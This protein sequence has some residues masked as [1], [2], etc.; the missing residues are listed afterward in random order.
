MVI[1]VCFLMT[2][3]GPQA[4]AGDH[5]DEIQLKK[6]FFSPLKFYQGDGDKH[7]V[8]TF[9]GLSFA[10]E[11]DEVISQNPEARKEAEKS[12]VWNGF[13]LIG[14]IGLFT[15][16][17]MI[18]LDTIDDAQK[19]SDGQMVDDD[20]NWNY[21]VYIGIAG[22]VMILSS[23]MSSSYLKRGIKI[24][25]DG[26]VTDDATGSSIL[27]NFRIYVDVDTENRVPGTEEPTKRLL[28]ANSS[29]KFGVSF[30]F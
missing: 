15:V 16:S 9:I 2:I 26:L 22:F 6:G 10:S 7:S 8:Y 18:L 19:V 30:S 24:F 28:F 13:G 14:S 5:P 12:F 3:V 27:S 4:F 25:N 17:L 23:I 29:L 1:L 11:F 21:L 20:F